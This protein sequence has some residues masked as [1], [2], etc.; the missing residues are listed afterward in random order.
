MGKL[1][2]TLALGLSIYLSGVLPAAAQQG[3]SQPQPS[4]QDA[5]IQQLMSRIEALEREVASLK[6]TASTTPARAPASAEQTTSALPASLSPAQT[7]EAQLAAKP[8]A[9]DPA[10]SGDAQEPS[11]FSFHG[12]ADINFQRN[13]LGDST[14]RFALGEID[15]F[16]TARISPRL[17]A[18][19]ETVLE[20]DNQVYTASV[21]INVERLLLQYRQNDYFNLDIGS[22]RTAIGYY[23]TAY[24]RGAWLRTAISSPEMFT[25]ED[26]GGFLPLHNAGVSVNGMIPSGPLGLYYVAETGSSRNYS[27][28]VSGVVD[29]SQNGAFNVALV[30]RPRG[31]PGLE[32]GLSSY[33]DRFAP[34]AGYPIHR[35]VWAAHVVYVARR[36]EWLNE[37]VLA[38]FTRT[39]LADASTPGFY[40]QIAYRVAPDWRPYF[41]VEH[42]NAQGY[43][44]PESVHDYIHWR[45]LVLGGVRYDIS[46][47]V[48]LKFELGHETD[49]LQP[50]WI[51]A[52]MQ[53]A[54]TF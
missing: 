44:G 29:Y 53:L 28:T 32:V 23:P 22:Y 36:V 2:S 34:S 3:Q 37:G 4:P 13:V 35:S 25:F 16:A 30:A 18:L 20:T 52:A 51:R 47:N 11:R 10:S 41:R 21:P 5:V 38:K 40:S 54:F 19:L 6:A 27:N 14:K 50:A 43:A 48:A 24:L 1:A 45:M 17:T 9:P 46:D 12:Y 42:M 33:R 15:L 31:I 8:T 26:D 49:W 39:G 7:P